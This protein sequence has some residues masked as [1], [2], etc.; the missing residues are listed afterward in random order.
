M[1]YK[2]NHPNASRWYPICYWQKEELVRLCIPKLRAGLLCYSPQASHAFKDLPSRWRLARLDWTNWSHA[3]PCTPTLLLAQVLTA[4]TYWGQIPEAAE[5]ARQHSY[6][7]GDALANAIQED[8]LPWDASVLALLPFPSVLDMMARDPVWLQQLGTAVLTERP[9]VMDAVQRMRRK[10]M[11]YGYLQ[12]NNY[13]NVVPNGG[14]IE[15]LPTNPGIV[16][17]PEYD[18]VLAFSRPAGVW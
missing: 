17:V 2:L 3:L 4:A 5:W 18:P 7:T 13:V 1:T 12:A 8:N 6:L 16:Y 10:A 9:E 14:Y 15:I 11:D